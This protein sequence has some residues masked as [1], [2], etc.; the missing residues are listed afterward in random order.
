MNDIEAASVDLL[1]HFRGEEN[2]IYYDRDDSLATHLAVQGSLGEISM[3]VG[4]TSVSNDSCLLDSD[5][6]AYMGDV[7]AN[8]S[9][10]DD[11]KFTTQIFGVQA[12]ARPSNSSTDAKKLAQAWK[13]DVETAQRTL[14]ATTLRKRRNENHKL[15]RNSTTND[16]LLRYSRLNDHIFMDTMIAKSKGGKSHRQKL[17]LIL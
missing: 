12:V 11:S 3:A 4:S 10:S 13:L 16:R 9:V 8:V 7:S 2:Y 1:P 14:N 5:G 15:E 17:V 6:D